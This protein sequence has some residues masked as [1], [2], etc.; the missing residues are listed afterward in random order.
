MIK[1]SCNQTQSTHH[2]F[3]HPL[4]FESFPKKKNSKQRATKATKSTSSSA[5]LFH[6]QNQTDGYCHTNSFCVAKVVFQNNKLG[7]AYSC[8]ENVTNLRANNKCIDTADDDEHRVSVRGEKRYSPLFPKYCCRS[9]DFCNLNFSSKLDN[10]SAFKLFNNKH[11]QKDLGLNVGS[12]ISR[13]S[14]SSSSISSSMTFTSFNFY[15]VTLIVTIFLAIILA[16]FSLAH[17]FVKKRKCSSS[18]RDT[19]IVN[20]NDPSEKL[21]KSNSDTIDN[22][23]SKKVYGI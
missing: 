12:S 22:A 21:I 18:S 16:T 8:D 15:L 5:S 14:S 3:N 19:I 7:M 2:C 23:C 10:F 9:G 6:I 4:P 17:I 11:E 1:C 13:I 20:F